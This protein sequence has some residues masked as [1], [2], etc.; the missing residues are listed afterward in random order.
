MESEGKKEKKIL[1][2]TDTSLLFRRG[3][4]GGK[5]FEGAGVTFSFPLLCINHLE[6]AEG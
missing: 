1:S 5:A 4:G 6:S 2:S 3:R